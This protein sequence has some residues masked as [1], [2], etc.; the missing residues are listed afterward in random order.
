MIAQYRKV[1]GSDFKKRAREIG[2]KEYEVLIL[3][4]IVEKETGAG[5][6][7]EARRLK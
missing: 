3:A 6:R 1:F 4:S 5:F 7:D 2:M